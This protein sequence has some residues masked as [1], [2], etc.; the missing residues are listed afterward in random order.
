[1]TLLER[2]LNYSND[3]KKFRDEKKLQIDKLKDKYNKNID[4]LNEK[5]NKF[6]CE[7]EGLYKEIDECKSDIKSNLEYYYREK[8]YTLISDYVSTFELEEVLNPKDSNTCKSLDELEK[9]LLKLLN[10]VKEIKEVLIIKIEEDK[11]VLKAKLEKDVLSIEEK[12]KELLNDIR[13]PLANDYSHIHDLCAINYESDSIPNCVD[14]LPESVTIG[15]CL[16]DSNDKLKEISDDV[17]LKIPLDIDMK[18]GGNIVIKINSNN[19][20][21]NDS[22]IENIIT[23]LALK[24]IESFPS[25][26]LRLGI[27]SSSITAFGKLSA[28]FAAYADGNMSITKET[29][30]TREQFAKLLSTISSKG[31]LINNK[32]LQNK[33]NNI[34]DL[35]ERGIRTEQ[36]QFVIVHDAFRDMS[37]DNINQFYGCISEMSRCGIRFIIIDDFSEEIY[38][39]KPEILKKI[40]KILDA[41]QVFEINGNE[42]IDKNQNK[43][44]FVTARDMNNTSVYNFINEY[45]SY[46]QSR[47]APY[48]SYEMV[49]FG[50]EKPDSSNFDSI[51]IPVALY[52]PN[53]WEIEFACVGSSPNANLILGVPGT[54]KSTLIDSL[55]MNGAMKYSP[56]ELNFRLLDFKDGISSSVYTMPDCRIP[57]IKVVS[58]NNKP[59]EAD[60]ILSNI[61]AEG[62]RRNK[63][64]TALSSEAK[65]NV[66]NIVDY[67]RLVASGKYNRKNMPR[68]IIVIDECQYLFNDEN[69]A[70]KCQ[71]IMK[72]CRSQGIHLILATQ[73]LSHRMW[74]A[75]KLI[76]GIYCFEIAKDDAEQLL[77]REYA[78]L[79]SS[80]VPKGS[81]MAFASNNRGEKCTKIRVAYDGG[82]TEKYAKAVREKWSNYPLD[83]VIVGDKSAKSISV[84]EYDDL[85]L[86]QKDNALPIGQDYSTNESINILY[87]K[88]YP[89]FLLGTNQNV[90]DSIFKLI[91][92]AAIKKDI[93]T[94][95]VDASDKQE[96]A[97]FAKNNLKENIHV[98]D[99]NGYLD[100]LNEVYKIYKQRNSK[101]DNKPV[102]FIVNGLQSV[103]DFL[104]NVKSEKPSEKSNE[105]S[106][107]YSPG[108]SLEEII[109]EKMKNKSVDE[110]INGKD[111]LIITLFN[112]AYKTNIFICVSLN[113][114]LLFDDRGE[115]VISYQHRNIIKESGY[116]ILYQNCSSDMKTIMQDNFKEKMMAEMSEDMAL[117][118]SKQNE[119]YKFRYFQ[120]KEVEE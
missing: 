101:E 104:N 115:Q 58:Q 107:N 117:L 17:V 84:K 94:Y 95:I 37:L 22:K 86:K 78:S 36:F 111:T 57:H 35:Y 67:N 108:L 2:V 16:I 102:F 97:K 8:A 100:S 98:A 9:E 3:T 63:E 28:L 85:L 69:L 71:D 4:S 90:P 24:Y 59:E 62:E 19:F 99:E 53:V 25:G 46:A 38:K 39:N 64:F 89:M 82:D 6:N 47:K 12:T 88:N 87:E 52:E 119:I 56:D 93:D 33:C 1:M 65:Q 15:N 49:G 60:I 112:N 7:L 34:Y 20:Y 23:G 54:G 13:L 81:Y 105:Q 76:E 75:V 18:N 103:P 109:K 66:R 77:K 114:L 110:S 55:I 120:L 48:L 11:N 32:L 42:C 72:K 113:T 106:R 40:N 68:L 91:T 118:S 61:L 92:Y 27:Y 30:K 73:T 31:E 14:I 43:V 79:I 80:E 26:Y 70:N 44:E 51:V 5:I 41:C 29:C 45:C 21:D 50:K 10:R 116:K 96:L 83:I 74:G